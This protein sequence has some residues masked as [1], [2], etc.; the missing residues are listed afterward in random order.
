MSPNAVG[1]VADLNHDGAVDLGDW[2]L[3]ADDWG[4]ERVLLDSDFDR[5]GDVDPNDLGMLMDWWLWVP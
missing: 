4:D 1:H 2:S 3:W 5:D